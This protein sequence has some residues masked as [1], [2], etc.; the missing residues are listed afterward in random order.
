MRYPYLLSL[1]LRSR[2]ERTT[3]MTL[4]EE[5][6]MKV[7]AYANVEDLASILSTCTRFHGLEERIIS[8]V[9]Q[10]QVLLW[11]NFTKT[12]WIRSW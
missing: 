2:V 1:L 7:F 11:W 8:G 6:L 9:L 4:P 10:A 5:S 12:R 3:I